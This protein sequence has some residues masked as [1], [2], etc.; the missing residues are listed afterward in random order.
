MHN[1]T[2]YPHYLLFRK[3]DEKLAEQIES[4]YLEYE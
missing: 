3:I 2:E 4:Q 1:I